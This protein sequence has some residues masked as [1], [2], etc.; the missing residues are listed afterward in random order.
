MVKYNA[1]IRELHISGVE[2]YRAVKLSELKIRLENILIQRKEGNIKVKWKTVTKLANITWR[3]WWFT[4][5]L[6][7]LIRQKVIYKK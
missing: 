3:T 4:L 6:T 7:R 1:F 5:N 2:Q